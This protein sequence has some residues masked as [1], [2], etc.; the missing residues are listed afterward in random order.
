MNKG[1]GDQVGVDVVREHSVECSAEEWEE[2]GRRARKYGM[3]VSE[4]VIRCCEQAAEE[5][6]RKEERGD[7]LVVWEDKLGLVDQNRDD[8]EGSGDVV[9]E[10]PGGEKVRL[11]V[12]EVIKFLL[13]SEERGPH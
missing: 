11:E 13:L 9:V 7:S 4:F 2:I 5:Q 8:L 6:K 3:S 1:Q 12:N 10:L